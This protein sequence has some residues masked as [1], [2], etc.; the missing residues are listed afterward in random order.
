M[1]RITYEKPFAP[2]LSSWGNLVVLP[3]HLLEGKDIT[4]SELTRKPVG[5]GM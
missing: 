3:K 5:L 2:A 4:K 1:F